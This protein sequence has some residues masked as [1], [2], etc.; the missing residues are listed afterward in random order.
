MSTSLRRPIPTLAGPVVG[1]SQYDQDRRD[2][3]LLQLNEI[4]DEIWEDY[5]PR[6]DHD[7]L[8][9]LFFGITRPPEKNVTPGGER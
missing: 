9:D 3:L 7:P 2:Q 4:D 6:R 5:V 1:L 8:Y